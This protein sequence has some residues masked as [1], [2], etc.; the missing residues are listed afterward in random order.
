[1][2]ENSIYISWAIGNVH[3]LIQYIVLLLKDKFEFERKIHI[4]NNHFYER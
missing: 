3:F 1:M 2:D 4:L